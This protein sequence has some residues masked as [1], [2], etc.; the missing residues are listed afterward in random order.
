MT[1]RSLAATSK[2]KRDFGYAATVSVRQGIDMVSRYG[3]STALARCAV[4]A[5]DCCVRCVCATVD[6][7]WQAVKEGRHPVH[8]PQ[9][10]VRLH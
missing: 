4:A 2:A 1:M 5:V 8:S 10:A 9:A 7:V 6:R 3:H